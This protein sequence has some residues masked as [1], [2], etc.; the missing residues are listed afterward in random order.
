MTKNKKPEVEEELIDPELDIEEEEELI[1]IAS[2][3]N[4]SARTLELEKAVALQERMKQDDKEKK[5]QLGK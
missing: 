4:S 1:D 5:A 2:V 3:Q